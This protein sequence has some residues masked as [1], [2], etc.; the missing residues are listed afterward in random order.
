M[1]KHQYERVSRW[2]SRI[3]N[4]SNA[5][6]Q[7]NPIDSKD[8]IVTFF[9]NCWH[10]K[11]WLMKDPLI[12]KDARL[13]QKIKDFAEKESQYIKI[14]Q[15]IANGSKHGE[16]EN[17]HRKSK[18]LSVNLIGDEKS[19][20]W[21]SAVYEYTQRNKTYEVVDLARKCVQ[22]WEKFLKKNVPDS[23]Q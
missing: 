21:Q 4:V 10:L 5:T 22:E 20:I 9:Q 8:Y 6:Y 12:A 19:G 2:F 3:E 13:I 7:M 17:F 16:F 23:I 15:N 1:W 14:S 11:D 18:G